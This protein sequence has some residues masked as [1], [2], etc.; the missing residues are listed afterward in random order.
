MAFAGF[1]SS[2]LIGTSLG[3][4]PA[5]SGALAVDKVLGP[6]SAEVRNGATLGAVK[7]NGR[8]GRICLFRSCTVFTYDKM[9]ESVGK[10]DFDRRTVRYFQTRS[11]LPWIHAFHHTVQQ[12]NWS[13]EFTPLGYILT[14]SFSSG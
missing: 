1:S 3:D 14:F 12:L 7:T 8:P 6:L 11:S 5:D 4:A 2:S 9:L 10:I 13:R